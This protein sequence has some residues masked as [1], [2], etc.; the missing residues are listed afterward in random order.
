MESEESSF[1]NLF[2]AAWHESGHV[3]IAHRHGVCF[4]SV[5]VYASADSY[6][7]AV[8]YV[9]PD[10]NRF[11]QIEVNA[12]GVASEALGVGLYPGSASFKAEVK[13]L[14]NAGG[15]SDGTYIR[16]R[17]TE[18]KIVD[19]NEKDEAI[20]LIATAV[21]LQLV[22]RYEDLTLLSNELIHKKKLFY[23]D[24]AKLFGWPIPC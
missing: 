17:L 18:M 20:I 22:E 5:S 15:G 4:L 7:G 24:V 10:W 23:S 13:R 16:N 3:L 14:F 2:R 11:P 6:S 8:E 9:S 12:A 21:G 19:G 1:A